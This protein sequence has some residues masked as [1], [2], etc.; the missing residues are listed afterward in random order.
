M[1]FKYDEFGQLIIRKDLF[2]YDPNSKNQNNQM[3]EFLTEN[4]GPW[5]YIETT[6][7]KPKVKRRSRHYYGR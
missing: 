2:Y 6:N 4:Y 1:N 5:V 7:L 3:K